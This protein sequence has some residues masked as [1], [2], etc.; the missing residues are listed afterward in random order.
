MIWGVP[1]GEQFIHVDVDLSDIGCFSLRPNDFLTNGYGIDSFKSSYEFKS[2]S[3]FNALPQIK[4][5]DKLKIV[6]DKWTV[7]CYNKL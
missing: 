6:V 7:I 3:D 5:F 4:S 1:L 2:N